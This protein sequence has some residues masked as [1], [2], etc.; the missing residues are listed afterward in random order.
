MCE[1]INGAC[2]SHLIALLT[3][4]FHQDF[5]SLYYVLI[6][7]LPPKVTY[8]TDVDRVAFSCCESGSADKNST[9]HH[10]PSLSIYCTTPPYLAA[11]LKTLEHLQTVHL[12]EKWE[13]KSLVRMAHWTDPW[14]FERPSVSSLVCWLW[15]ISATSGSSNSDGCVIDTF[16]DLLYL[17]VMYLLN[18][19]GSV[20]CQVFIPVA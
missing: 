14:Q 17:R 8:C 18:P 6:F 11:R 5:L 9:L 10:I 3:T 4:L 12:V 16:S 20:E 2:F 19:K 15:W 7:R 1:N 13:N